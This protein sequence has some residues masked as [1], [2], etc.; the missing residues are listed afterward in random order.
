M[1]DRLKILNYE[2]IC[3]IERNREINY[4]HYYISHIFIDYTF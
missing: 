2:F 1:H 3:K 4:H